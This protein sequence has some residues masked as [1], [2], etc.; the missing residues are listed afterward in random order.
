[1]RS[2][3]LKYL[4]CAVFLIGILSVNQSFAQ[5][6]EMGVLGGV[7]TY[8]GELSPSLFDYQLANPALGFL[9]RKNFN[10]HWAQRLALN[11]GTIEGSDAISTDGFKQNRNL[12]FRSRILDIHYLFEFNFFPYQIANPET[13]FTPFVFAGI[14]VF[15]FNPQAELGGKWYDLQPLGTEGQG[16]S[17]YPDRK[18]YSLVQVG[19]PF[20][21]GFK[22]KF[23]RRFGVTLELG[24]RRLYTDYLDDVS[25]TYADKTVLSASNGELSAI[26]SD[27]S[28]EG[29]TIGNTNRQRGN[30]SD[31]DWYMFTGITF[32]YTL[33]KKYSDNCRPFK[34]KLR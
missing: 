18:K 16:T 3:T 24:A 17:A 19:I 13:F 2:S 12:S 31:N 29:Q 15:S 32:N 26:L 1:M 4:F 6:Y 33:S 23:S 5:S 21:G 9:I 7:A 28:A 22:F 8:K 34:G 10:N 14:N 25:T 30:A 11:F 20:G 27:R